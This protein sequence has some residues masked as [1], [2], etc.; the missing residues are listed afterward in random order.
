MK[1]VFIKK[2]EI[3]NE[4]IRRKIIEIQNGQMNIKNMKVLI[5]KEDSYL[6]GHY[7][8]YSEIMYILKGKAKDYRMTNLDTNETEVYQLEEGDVVFRTGKI[9]HGGWFEK[10]SIVIDGAESSYLSREFND[11]VVEGFK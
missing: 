1:G 4:D 3:V 7:H 5:V 9:V 2:A 6:G 10:G 11:V 8:Y